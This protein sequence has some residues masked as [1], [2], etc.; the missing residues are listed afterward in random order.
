MAHLR[1]YIPHERLTVGTWQGKTTKGK[2]DRRASGSL[3]T[4]INQIQTFLKSSTSVVIDDCNELERTRRSYLK[5]GI[6]KLQF[7]CQVLPSNVKATAVVFQ[8]E[9][10][11]HQC[12]YQNEFNLAR[13]AEMKEAVRRKVITEDDES[14]LLC[15]CYKEPN[16]GTFEVA[17]W[18]FQLTHRAG[19]AGQMALL[20]PSHNG[21]RLHRCESEKVRDFRFFDTLLQSRIIYRR[22][23]TFASLPRSWSFLVP[24]KHR[25]YSSN[26]K[27]ANHNNRQ[28][29]RDHPRMA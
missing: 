19:M 5:V 18:S 27:L 24:P 11:I 14:T 26:T 28:R 9:G 25:N 4:F 23:G 15:G 7:D 8:A 1:E 12:Q 3:H 10:E 2:K 16:M 13:D 21:R 17:L 22:S 6:F 29:G 20:Y